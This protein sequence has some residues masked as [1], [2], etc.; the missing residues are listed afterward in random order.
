MKRTRVGIIG[1]G[2]IGTQH[3]DALRRI[4]EVEIVAICATDAEK[5]R[6]LAARHGIP[7]AGTSYQALIDE[8]GA[9]VIHNCTPTVLHTAVNR[10]AISAGK[11]LYAEKPL[12]ATSAEA[13]D[14]WQQ[15]ERAGILHGMNYQYRMNAAVQ[16]MRVRVQR[17]DMQRVFLA[18]GHYMQQSSLYAQDFKPRMMTEGMRCALADIGTHWV[19]TARCVLGR[20]VE[21]VFADIRTVHPVRTLPDGSE[22]SVCTDDLSTVLL[23]F[24]GGIQGALI[25]SKVSAGHMNDL[26]LEIQ[27]QACSLA[28]QQE[29]PGRLRIGYKLKSDERLQVSPQLV[30]PEVAGLVTMP[31][32]HMPGWHD[33][34]LASMQTYYDALR[35]VIPRRAMQ[36]ATF[37]DG[38]EATAFVEAA[39]ASHETGAWAAV[40]RP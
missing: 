37:A 38:F 32:G 39:I 36:C 3:L 22:A 12:A 9:E 17:G 6:G 23:T 27:G 1:M 15:A 4:P 5:V 11:H 24:E 34:L 21:R 8:G 7:W 25:V 28:W 20:R 35:G 29:D 14:I 31:G 10:A 33:A 16:E 18:S 2:M 40:E 19:D 30:D 26:A 13:Y